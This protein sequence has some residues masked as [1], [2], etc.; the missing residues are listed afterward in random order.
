MQ[1]SS[2]IFALKLHHAWHRSR[3]DCLLQRQCILRGSLILSPI[4]YAWERTISNSLLVVLKWLKDLQF[5]NRGMRTVHQKNVQDIFDLSVVS[6]WQVHGVQHF[7]LLGTIPEISHSNARKY[8]QVDIYTGQIK[9]K[10]QQSLRR[11]C[12]KF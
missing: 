3:S 6:R 8:S 5:D 12:N 11:L 1:N 4:H 10:N 7:H 9:Q 2:S